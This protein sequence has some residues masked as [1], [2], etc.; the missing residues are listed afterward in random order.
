MHPLAARLRAEATLQAEAPPGGRPPFTSPGGADK[1]LQAKQAEVD[2]LQK[3]LD[4][5]GPKHA[6]LVLLGV[7]VGVVGTRA[8]EGRPYQSNPAWKPGGFQRMV[9]ELVAQGHSE[10]SARRIAASIGRR[11][12][13]QAE[14]TRRSK[15][16][17]KAAR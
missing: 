3:E 10:D 11:K 4:S 5:M 6:L 16:G 2:R 15:L 8:L 12:Y 13:G 17:K 9:D 14:M 7:V 1:A